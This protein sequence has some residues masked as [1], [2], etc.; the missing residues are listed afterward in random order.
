MAK[1][2]KRHSRIKNIAIAF[3]LTSE[4]SAGTLMKK[5]KGNEPP[6]FSSL[7]TA[8]PSPIRND[9]EIVQYFSHKISGKIKFFFSQ[10]IWW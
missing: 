10:I 9:K 4:Q 6:L 8:I 5:V 7:P 1:E 2:R 3:E